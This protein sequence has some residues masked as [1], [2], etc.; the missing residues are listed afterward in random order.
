MAAG[1]PVF[2]PGRVLVVWGWHHL[3]QLCI[4]GVLG[5]VRAAVVG[6]CQEVLH[7]RAADGAQG[8]LTTWIIPQLRLVLC[9]CSMAF[10]S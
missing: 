7:H 1:D 2:F 6:V 3:L 10:S 8:Q 9:V 4:V 5:S